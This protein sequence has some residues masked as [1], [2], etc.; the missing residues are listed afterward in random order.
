MKCE[1]CDTQTATMWV[2]KPIVIFRADF[3]D[4]RYQPLLS[5]DDCGP[6]LGYV[7]LAPLGPTSH[8]LTWHF[9]VDDPDAISRVRIKGSWPPDG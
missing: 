8:I 3:V 9:G 4:Y 2:E 6:Q 1:I 7:I 5:C